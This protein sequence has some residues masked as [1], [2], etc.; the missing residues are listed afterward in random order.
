M[1]APDTTKLHALLAELDHGAPSEAEVLRLCAL[2]RWELSRVS[3]DKRLYHPDTLLLEKLRLHT[4]VA[5]PQ[6]MA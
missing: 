6:D 5:N 1:S 2:M 4:N 3:G